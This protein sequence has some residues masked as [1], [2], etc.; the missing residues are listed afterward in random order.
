MTVTD[1][2]G[3]EVTVEYLYIPPYR[4]ERDR[5][6]VPLEPDEPAS[7]E[8]QSVITAKGEDITDIISGHSRLW[9]E[10]LEKCMEDY[11]ESE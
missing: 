10:I 5:F 2:H 1:I 3:M 9:P 7:I 8:I 6:G 11:N 4:G